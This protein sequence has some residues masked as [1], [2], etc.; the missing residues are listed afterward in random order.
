MIEVDEVLAYAVA[1]LLDARAVLF[2]YYLGLDRRVKRAASQDDVC[3]Q[4]MTVPG[5]S[6]IAALASRRRLM[7]LAGSKILVRWLGTLASHQGDTSLANTTI[8]AASRKQAI[9]MCEPR[10]TPPKVLYLCVQ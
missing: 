7:T 2:Q 9:K 5:V 3:M 8:P 4:V 10:S 1:P 6:P